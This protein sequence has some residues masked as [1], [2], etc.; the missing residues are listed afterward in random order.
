MSI[1]N[2]IYP[3]GGNEVLNTNGIHIGELNI[4]PDLVSPTT[5]TTS[6]L[7]GSGS[8]KAYGQFISVDG[9][10]FIGHDP[11]NIEYTTV[12]YSSHVSQLVPTGMIVSISGIYNIVSSITISS[13]F[14][15]GV[16]EMYNT[17]NGSPLFPQ[18]KI[19]IQQNSVGGD[20]ASASTNLFVQLTAGDVVGT[21]FRNGTSDDEIDISEY[22]LSVTQIA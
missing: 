14:H 18:F 20:G 15:A 17:V 6:S 19:V 2:I 8:T 22:A 5:I 11:Q 10:A 3:N 21:I 1:N 4:V 7:A 16:C 13:V 12:S 9:Q